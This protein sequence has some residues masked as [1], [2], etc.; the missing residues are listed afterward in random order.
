MDEKI[1]L[2]LFARLMQLSAPTRKDLLEYMGQGPVATST[3]HRA[4][5]TCGGDVPKTRTDEA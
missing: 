4:V 3:V 2:G 5:N 1:D